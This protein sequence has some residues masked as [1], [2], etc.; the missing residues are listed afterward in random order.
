MIYTQHM[1]FDGTVPPFLA[2]EF[3]IDNKTHEQQP[4]VDKFPAKLMRFPHV[5][6]MFTQCNH[7]NMETM[8][9]ICS[10]TSHIGNDDLVMIHDYLSW[11]YKNH[12]DMFIW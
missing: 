4:C 5:F 7:L 2:P 6:C 12:E 10:Y 11:G 9:G 8:M 3:P 1:V